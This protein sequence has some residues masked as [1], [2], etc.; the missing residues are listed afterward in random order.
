MDSICNITDWTLSHCLKCVR[1]VTLLVLRLTA[2]LV[3][4]LLLCFSITLGTSPSFLLFCVSFLSLNWWLTHS[5]CP[6]P[7]PVGHCVCVWQSRLQVLITVWHCSSPEHA[8]L[9]LYSESPN[10]GII[11]NIVVDP[12]FSHSQYTVTISFKI[13]NHSFAN[14]LCSD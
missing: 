12:V 9:S 13:W 4:D 1:R 14:Q 2:V 7:Q 5:L 6:L 11:L 3:E 8:H 10:I